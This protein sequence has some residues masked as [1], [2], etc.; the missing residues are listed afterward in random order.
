MCVNLRHSAQPEIVE[1]EGGRVQRQSTARESAT[2]ASSALVHMWRPEIGGSASRCAAPSLNASLLAPTG[3]TT[4]C[5]TW[6]DNR[7]PV[8]PPQHPRRENLAA[9]I[10]GEGQWHRGWTSVT[11]WQVLTRPRSAAYRA[12]EP[13]HPARGR[14]QAADTRQERDQLAI[15][16]QR[17]F[18][19]ACLCMKLDHRR[20]CAS[21]GL[22]RRRRHLSSQV[23]EQP[24]GEMQGGRSRVRAPSLA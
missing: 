12:A 22:R 17:T 15:D 1:Q 5:V 9:W 19:G 8:R 3:C 21:A 4:R 16:V 18:R 2:S 23:R 20:R 14:S 10:T 7:T 13:P 11:P 24:T 6:A